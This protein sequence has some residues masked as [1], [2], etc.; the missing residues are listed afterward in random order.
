M[1]GPIF[2]ADAGGL[3]TEVDLSGGN[4]TIVAVVLVVS[5]VALA[6]AFMFRSRNITMGGRDA[7]SS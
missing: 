6:M 3:A 5:L 7:R 1:S 2:A 4:L